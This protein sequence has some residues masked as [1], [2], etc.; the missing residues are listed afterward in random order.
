[1]R[2]RKRSYSASSSSLSG[3]S[4]LAPTSVTRGTC[5]GRRGDAVHVSA[6]S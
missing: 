6:G 3:S 4:L 5:G 1:L 2:S